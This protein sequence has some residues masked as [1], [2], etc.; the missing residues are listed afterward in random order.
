MGVSIFSAAEGGRENFEVL[1]SVCRGKQSIFATKIIEVAPKNQ[2]KIACGALAIKK[3]KRKCATQDSPNVPFPDSILG[4]KM[5]K[6]ENVGFI[7]TGT[8]SVL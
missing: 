5:H 8:S 2:Q 3:C 1:R 7:L 6:C 4:G